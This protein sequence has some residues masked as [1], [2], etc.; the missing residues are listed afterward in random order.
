MCKL[1]NSVIRLAENQ[2][3]SHLQTTKEGLEEA[4]KEDRALVTEDSRSADQAEEVDQETTEEIKEPVEATVATMMTLA[5]I[6][7]AGVDEEL[8][9]RVIQVVQ[10]TQADQ[11]AQGIPIETIEEVLEARSRIGWP[12]AWN[13]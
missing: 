12:N 4:N 8:E 6:V 5:G 9:V 1:M 10:E 7:V 2:A 13:R 3:T 11:V